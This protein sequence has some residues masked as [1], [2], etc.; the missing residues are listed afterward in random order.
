MSVASS[1][2]GQTSN[3]PLRIGQIISDAFAVSLRN[4]GWALLL[5]LGVFAALFGFFDSFSWAAFTEDSLFLPVD[6]TLNIWL[7]YLLFF[8]AGLV[9]LALYCA[10]IR[11]VHDRHVDAARPVHT[12]CLAGAKRFLPTFGLVLIYFLAYFLIHLAVTLFVFRPPAFALILVFLATGCFAVYLVFPY[13][14]SFVICINEGVGP[15][16]ALGRSRSL[17]EG[18][19]WP[20]FGMML[21]TFVIWFAYLVVSDLLGRAFGTNGSIVAIILMLLAFPLMYAWMAGIYS[22]A[23]YRLRVLKEGIDLNGTVANIFD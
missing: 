3:A 1:S 13:L 21:L 14:L 4:Y 2:P 17:S 8:V 6:T 7:F 11:L 22:I 23:A 10:M 19:R 16:R 15:I 12:T 18:Y 9:A 20:L 5:N